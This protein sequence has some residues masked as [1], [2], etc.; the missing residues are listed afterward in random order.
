LSAA[1]VRG[2]RRRVIQAVDL[3]DETLTNKN[4]QIIGHPRNKDRYGSLSGGGMLGGALV[5]LKNTLIRNFCHTKGYLTSAP[6]K[7]Q[8]QVFEE[9]T[10]LAAD[11]TGFLILAEVKGL[12]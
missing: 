1:R 2:V 7:L 9:A 11:G 8:T 5:C 10:L 6:G 3:D 4:V 12:Q